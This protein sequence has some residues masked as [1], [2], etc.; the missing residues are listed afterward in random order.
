[1]CTNPT[2]EENVA[3]VVAAQ[4]GDRSALDELARQFEPT[5]RS[6]ARGM[7][8]GREDRDDRVD[9]V[10]QEAFLILL[11]KMHQVSDPRAFAGWVK[12]VAVTAVLQLSRKRVM[13][14]ADE[15]VVKVQYKDEPTPLE[16]L[17]A[18]N[19]DGQV[20]D[21]L[22]QM[23]ESLRDLLVQHY[24]KGVP[25]EELAVT[26]GTKEG[27]IKSRLFRARQK[28]RDLWESMAGTATAS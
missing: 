19:L 15:D 9:D 11:R 24:I 3:V 23:D 2:G 1:M 5:I 18:G 28:F 13:A 16:A 4:R 14:Q 25:L 27:T 17:S 26:L 20:A 21:A 7:L 10:V 22:D 6:V 8:R 12:Q